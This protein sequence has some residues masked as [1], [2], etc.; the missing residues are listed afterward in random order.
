M[1]N[2]IKIN[3]Q[4][5]N[6]RFLAILL[7]VLGHSI[8]IFDPNWEIFTSNNS[9]VTLFYLKQI[10]NLIQM[11][12]F[13]VISGFLFFYTINN[14]KIQFKKFFQKKIL[15]L[16]VP[17]LIFGI[18][19]LLPMRLLVGYSGYQSHGLPYNILVN[20]LYGQDNGHLWFLPTLFLSFMLAYPLFKFL[21]T[22]KKIDLLIIISA[23][24]L[25]LFMTFLPTYL[26]RLCEY[27][28]WFV[29]GYFLNKYHI[30]KHLNSYKKYILL[31]I[32]VILTIVILSQQF[33]F[34]Y[35]TRILSIVCG[36]GMVLT[37]FKF[38]PQ[39]NNKLVTDIS[40]ASFGIYLLHSPMIYFV[41]K[42]LPD[43]LPIAIVLI[44][45][46]GLGGLAYGLTKL[47]KKTPLK[48]IIGE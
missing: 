42:Y 47:I 46:V 28:V 40:N 39:N 3:Q 34:L 17:F 44:N 6:I 24:A 26:G 20:I 22:N 43:I 16:L 35:L 31:L 11:P 32:T 38:M 2:K 9:S 21:K 4:I 7:V 25:A 15:R 18:F 8:I 1:I 37:I 13:F 41:F 33:N 10:I 19:Y 5:V 48:F 23:L 45:F 30:S 27:F 12:L 29:L 14:P 36:I